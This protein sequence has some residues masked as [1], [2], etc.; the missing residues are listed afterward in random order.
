MI[1]A[2]G[3]WI[4]AELFVAVIVHFLSWDR[5]KSWF[6]SRDTEI[7]AND[8]QLR[9]TLHEKMKTGQHRVVFG[10]FNTATSKFIE[11]ETVVADTIDSELSE[12]HKDS[13][14]VVYT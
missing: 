14:L 2:A 3:L 11:G 4:L 5:I 7:N 6:T 8:D 10:I 1:I 12:F 13:P 9:V